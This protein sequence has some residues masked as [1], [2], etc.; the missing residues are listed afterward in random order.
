MGKGARAHF[1]E[2]DT[3]LSSA[4]LISDKAPLDGPQS[5]Y[6]ADSVEK[7]DHDEL[8]ETA[9]LFI[10]I[11]T[12]LSYFILIVVGHVVDLYDGLFYPE[13]FKHLKSQNVSLDPLRQQGLA[14]ISSGFDT[15]YYRRLYCRIGDVFSRPITNVP[16]RTVTLLEREST[17]V[18]GEYR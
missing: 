15:F 18:Q 3:P 13:K 6:N 17:D 9:P 1:Q 16:G 10:L 14:P 12:Y 8:I 5:L 4:D 2:Y 11:S 7:V